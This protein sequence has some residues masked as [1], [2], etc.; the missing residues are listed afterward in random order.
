MAATLVFSILTIA[1]AA[2]AADLADYVLTD[3]CIMSYG[4]TGKDA[5][6]SRLAQSMEATP[7]QAL[8]ILLAWSS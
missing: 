5:D 7:F 8:V 6:G 2:Q 1:G 3:V 4:G